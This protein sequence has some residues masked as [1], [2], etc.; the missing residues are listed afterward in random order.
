MTEDNTALDH[1]KIFSRNEGKN[2]ISNKIT[3]GE[4]SNKLKMYL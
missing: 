3:R 1:L 4:S 2:D